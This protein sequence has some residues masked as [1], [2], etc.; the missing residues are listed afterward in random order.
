MNSTRISIDLHQGW[1]CLLDCKQTAHGRFSGVAEI[2]YRGRAAGIVVI[3]GQ[4]NL[5][6]A[7]ARAKLRGSQFVKART[8]A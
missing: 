8:S 6:S 3:V 1:W 5:A 7:V 4:P 2:A